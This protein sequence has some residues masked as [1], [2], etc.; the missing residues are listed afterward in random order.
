[1]ELIR[2]EYHVVVSYE[3]QIKNIISNLLSGYNRD[4]QLTKE[5]TMKGLDT[6]KESLSIMSLI[7]ENL[8]VNGENCRKALSKDVYATERVY[9]LVKRGTTF[10]E[11]YRKISK[12]EKI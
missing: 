12:N 10:R 11:A 6:I 9:K 1:M 2:T 4:L 5:P 8:K 7:F 3:F